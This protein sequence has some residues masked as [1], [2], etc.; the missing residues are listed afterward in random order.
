[1]STRPCRRHLNSAD[2]LVTPYE[3]VR[4]GF[5]AMAMEKNRQ[6]TPFIQQA[7][8]LRAAVS[9]FSG[10][11]ELLDAP[12]IEPSLL[13]AAGVSDKATAYLQESDRREAILALIRNYLE[14]QGQ[15]WVEELLYRFLLTRGDSLGGMMRNI[16]GVLAQRKTTRAILS[17]L[18][19]IGETYRYWDNESDLWLPK[20]E[21]D[22]DVE[23]RV[24]GI[25][26][27]S[28]G[29][30]RALVFNIKVPAVNKNV[31]M[32]L[33]NCGPEDLSTGRVSRLIYQ[34]NELYLALGELKGGIDP[35]GADEHWKTASTALKRIR[36]AFGDSPR[37]PLLF[38]IGAAIERDMATEIWNQLESDALANAANLTNDTQLASLCLWLCEL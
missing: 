1:M 12:H 4:A 13:V 2:D 25:A 33:L 34:S 22:A 21:N 26:W 38:F 3:A 20:P 11:F 16:A 36:Q 23:L 27:Q 6:A 37:Q 18:G 19:V 32:C 35:A 28:R 15:N 8:S 7:R 10:P 30:N 9:G 24:K 17:A 29:A 5:V 14:P 31:D